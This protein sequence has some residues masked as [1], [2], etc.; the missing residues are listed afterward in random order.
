MGQF[1]KSHRRDG[2]LLYQGS[3]CVSQFT[4][5]RQELMF[6]K[7]VY[8]L[9]K[10]LILKKDPSTQVIFLDEAMKVRVDRLRLIHQLCAQVLKNV[11]V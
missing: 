3:P 7:Q 11:H 8:T 1:R 9:E 6:L 2:R 10:V 5:I 4:F